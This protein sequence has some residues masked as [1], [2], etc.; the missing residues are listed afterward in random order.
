[1]DAEMSSDFREAAAV[2]RRARNIFLGAMLLGAV[3]ALYVTQLRDRPLG[4]FHSVHALLGA[5]LLWALTTAVYA[6][7]AMVRAYGRMADRMERIVATD[8]VKAQRL[9]SKIRA[10]LS[11]AGSAEPLAS[12]EDPAEPP[13]PPRT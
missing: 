13:E 10:R 9:V 12:D 7:Y 5:F 8:E 1:M 6:F 4:N 3:V 2:A 11:S